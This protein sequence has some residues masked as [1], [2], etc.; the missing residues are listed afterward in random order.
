MDNRN[1]GRP[2]N[3]TL[4]TSRVEKMIGKYVGLYYFN[5]PPSRDPASAMYDS[6]GGLDDLDHM[7]NRLPLTR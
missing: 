7:S 4:L 1:Y 3:A 6:I 2:P 5:L